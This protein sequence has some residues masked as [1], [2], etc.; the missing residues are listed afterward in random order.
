MKVKELVIGDLY[1]IDPDPTIVGKLSKTG[2]LQIHKYTRVKKHVDLQ[3][4]ASSK[5]VMVYLGRLTSRVI[6]VPNHPV[7]ESAH[8]FL[9]EGERVYI[10]GENIRHIIPF[11]DDN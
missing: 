1:C 11:I 5:T 9:M 4:L 10:Y 6:A 2:W 7:R 3:F 8:S